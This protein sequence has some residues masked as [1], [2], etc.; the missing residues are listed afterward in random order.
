MIIVKFLGGVKKLFDA[1]EVKLNH[2]TITIEEVFDYLKKIK[3]KNTP[4][5]DIKNLIVAVNGVD[6]SL[7]NGKLTKLKNRWMRTEEQILKRITSNLH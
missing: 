6:S 4:N 1:E 7:M 2:K 5:L 3:P